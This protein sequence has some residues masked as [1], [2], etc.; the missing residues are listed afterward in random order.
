MNFVNFF[1]A[2]MVSTILNSLLFHV[3]RLHNL[4]HSLSVN[5]IPHLRADVQKSAV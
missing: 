5:Y 1:L 3:L 4:K 2:A